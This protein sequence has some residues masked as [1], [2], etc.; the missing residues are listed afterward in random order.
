ML[1]LIII[2]IISIVVKVNYIA[3]YIRLSEL[4]KVAIIISV[5]TQILLM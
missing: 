5:F 1:S 4:H 2:V 3:L